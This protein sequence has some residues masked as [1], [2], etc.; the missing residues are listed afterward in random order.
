MIKQKGNNCVTASAAMIAEFHGV[1]TDQNQLAVL[2]SEMSANNQ[3]TYPSEMLLAMQKL[4]FFGDAFYWDERG[5]FMDDIL[6]LIREALFEIGPIYISFRPNVFGI[7]GHGCVVVGYDDRK[8]ELHFYNPWGNEFEKEY[9]LVAAEANGIVLIEP[10]N[11][12]PVATETYIEKIRSIIPVFCGDF[13]DLSTEL[14][15]LGQ[16]HELVWCSRR[17]SRS[18][19]RFAQDTA[20][21]D[22]RMILELAF[23]RNPAVLIPYSQE[24]VTERYLLVT[25]PPAG[26]AR[27]LV[28]H[29]SR[30]GW[31]KPKLQTLGNLTRYWVT[32]F[33]AKEST[34]NLWELPMI[35][36]R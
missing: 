33:N 15:R 35:E 5:V 6:P 27:Y 8:K 26:G 16:A 9:E 22:G 25:R 3:G 21:D 1:K 7:E 23:E 20:R 13:I 18:D 31:S 32:A 4:G 36:L 34:Y 29:I 11:I 2:S 14:K 24:G 12:K 30:N 17:D 28:Y 19:K 10:A